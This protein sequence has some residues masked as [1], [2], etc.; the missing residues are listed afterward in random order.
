MT[1]SFEQICKGKLLA[2]AEAYA[3]QKN[4]KLTTLGRLVTNDSP[5]FSRLRADR[6]SFTVRKYDE[7]LRWFST[8]WPDD[9]AWP[10]GVER[11]AAPR[12]EVAA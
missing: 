12:S 8:N 3:A 10:D 5:F 4:I 2:C 6:G 1:Q 9:I 7:V 11:P